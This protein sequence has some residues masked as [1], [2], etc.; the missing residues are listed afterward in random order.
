MKETLLSWQDALEIDGIF[1]N[2]LRSFLWGIVKGLG[3]I[4]DM[5]YQ[6]IDKAYDLLTFIDSELINKLFG[7]YQFIFKILFTLAMCGL[8]IYLVMGKKEDRSNILTNIVIIL[9]IVT[10][11]PTI[12]G[13]LT[14]FTK[15]SVDFAKSQSVK[16]NS[17]V[18]KI[19]SE[20]LIDLKVVDSKS[21]GDNL[22]LYSDVIRDKSKYN[23]L[24][25]ANAKQIYKAININE[26]MSDHKSDVF[27][28]KIYHDGGSGNID[29]KELESGVFKYDEEYYRYNI[30]F[31]SV[32]FIILTMCVAFFFSMF[33]VIRTIFEIGWNKIVVLFIAST[34]IVKGERMKHAITH[35]I[36]LFATLFLVAVMFGLYLGSVTYLNTFASS[37]GGGIGSFVKIIGMI[38]L[39]ML[40]ID[41]PNMIEQVIGIDSGIS[42]GYRM[43][44]S[45]MAGLNIAKNI[46]TMV[47]RGIFGRKTPNSQMSNANNQNVKAGLNN[48]NNNVNNQSSESSIGVDNSKAEN[49][50]ASSNLN[51]QNSS[52]ISANES[53]Q[54]T[55]R[56]MASNINSKMPSQSKREGGIINTT[57][58]IARQGVRGAVATGQFA[59]DNKDNLGGAVRKVASDKITN[60]K[61][62]LSSKVKDFAGVKEKGYYSKETKTDP[63]KK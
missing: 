5:L 19:V 32:I 15:A 9:I 25:S 33:K 13:Y 52:N 43:M 39:A 62:N 50:A 11:M 42:S 24:S 6:A 57:K 45:T 30:S 38:A 53:S 36:G 47:N 4:L 37:I 1:E 35:I 51:E 22:P 59:R 8:G 63:K 31:G 14:N 10:A 20:N 16:E 7:Q 18:T 3:I 27:S 58:N 40:L 60:T 17:V 46:G 21:S 44:M 26:L 28:K 23:Y 41:G 54:N 49:K 34:D 12:S 48:N 61:Q 2:I 56:D 29:V 55:K